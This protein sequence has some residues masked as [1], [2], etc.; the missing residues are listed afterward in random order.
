MAWGGV[1]NGVTSVDGVAP[2]DARGWGGAVS[3]GHWWMV[4]LQGTPVDWPC[5]GAQGAEKREE[6]PP[7]PAAPPG[8]L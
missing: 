6:T 3:R 2:V 7:G 5:E 4:W 1:Q 8:G